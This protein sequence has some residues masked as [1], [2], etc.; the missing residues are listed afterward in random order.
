[1]PWIVYETVN[2]INGKLYLGVHRQDSP[3]FDGYLGSGSVLL[4]AIAKHGR[5]SFERRTLFEFDTP[6]EAYAKE[7]ELVGHE[8]VES[9]ATYNVKHGGLGGGGF[10]MPESS[11]QRIREYR[12]GRPHTEETKELIRRLS[13]AKWT[14]ERRARH[15]EIMSE[16]NRGRVLGEESR[17]KISDSMRQQWRDGRRGRKHAP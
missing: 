12:Q 1:M 13:A 5:E 15:S 16:A 2:K 9:T 14:P 8:W 6:E 10:S 17:R 4:A 11:K 3:G 7:R